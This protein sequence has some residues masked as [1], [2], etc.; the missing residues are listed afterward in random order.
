MPDWVYA[1]ILGVIEGLTEFIPVSSTGHL[2]LAGIDFP[3]DVRPLIESHHERWDGKGYP[4]GLAG[5]A[6]PLTARIL[7]LPCCQECYIPRIRDGLA[8]DDGAAIGVEDLARHV[9]G[10][11]AGEEQ[12]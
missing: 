11:L 8:P 1:I 7:C 3:W 4:H 12:E 10:I 5:E 9:A 2:M 6:I